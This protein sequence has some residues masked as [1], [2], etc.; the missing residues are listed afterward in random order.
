L[1]RRDGIRLNWW[2]ISALHCKSEWP[3]ER[4]QVILAQPPCLAFAQAHPR[5][6]DSM[7]DLVVQRHGVAAKVE[8]TGK[9]FQA[10][11]RGVINEPSHVEI[12]SR[13]DKVLPAFH[14]FKLPANVAPNLL[15]RKAH[16]HSS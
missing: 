5:N 8:A 2:I 7:L 13:L 1:E 16:D 15:K 11:A 12:D 3:V 4:R 10:F 6:C 14:A 9:R